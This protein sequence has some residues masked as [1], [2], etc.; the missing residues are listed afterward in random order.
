MRE[1]TKYY[2][3]G[4]EKTV[5]V[6]VCQRLYSQESSSRRAAKSSIFDQRLE[7]FFWFGFSITSMLAMIAL[8]MLMLSN[9]IMSILVYTY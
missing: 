3:L 2:V 6:Y 8:K 7:Y 9:K 4:T 5:L 1:T